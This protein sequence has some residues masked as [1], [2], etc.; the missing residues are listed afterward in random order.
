M[1]VKGRG[2]NKGDVSGGREGREEGGR[3]KMEENEEE[4][5][6]EYGRLENLCSPFLI[7]FLFSLV[8]PLF[9]VSRWVW[10]EEEEVK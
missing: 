5:A 8:P 2:R 7:F 3:E 10:R 6:A 9:Y 4:K 1:V